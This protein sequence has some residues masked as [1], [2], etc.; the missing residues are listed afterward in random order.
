MHRLA[1]VVGCTLSVSC[2]TWTE[3]GP[4][5]A[6]RVSGIVATDVNHVW[7]ATPGG[8]VWKSSDGGAN[9]T[10]AG[11]YGLGDF[12]DVALALDRNDPSRMYLRAWS[13]FLVSTD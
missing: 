9:F 2:A 1:L 5:G 4:K 12:T 3:L 6:G 7:V 13:G 11:N 10:W 8:G